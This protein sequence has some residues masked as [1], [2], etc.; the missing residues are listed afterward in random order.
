MVKLISVNCRI[1]FITLAITQAQKQ[2][3]VHQILKIP[4]I[5]PVSFWKELNKCKTLEATF[6]NFQTNFGIKSFDASLSEIEGFAQSGITCIGFWQS[7]FP[8][9]LKRLHDAPPLLWAKGSVDFLQH[10]QMAIV[11]GRNASF[12]GINFAQDLSQQLSDHGFTIVSGLA[13]GID[14][15]AHQGALKN[16]TIAVLA[17]GVDRLYPV[18]N[19]AIYEQLCKNHLVVS[20]MPPG[21]EPTAALFPRRNRIIAALS[22]GICIIEAALKS[23]SLL[24]AKYG[25]DLGLPIFACPGHP[26][27]PRTKGSNKLIKDG[28]YLLDNSMDVIEQIP[29]AKMG[30]IKP[31]ALSPAVELR[32]TDVLSQEIINFL[33]HTPVKVEDLL[34]HLEHHPTEQVLIALSELE[35]KAAIYRPSADLVVL[36]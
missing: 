5:G 15:A 30:T 7:D 26:Y 27:D 6:K 9:Q 36:G 8:K 21:V 16:S 20:E 12:H 19:T 17:G 10:S 13:R 14:K 23:G 28:A 25:L 32:V 4:R 24:T 34:K 29:I 18:E 11:G 35:L 1:D 22:S 31:I 3:M 33:S 2:A